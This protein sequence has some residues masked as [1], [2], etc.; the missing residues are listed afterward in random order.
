MSRSN[1]LSQFTTIM[2]SWQNTRFPWLLLAAVSLGMLVLAHAVFQVWLFM[3]PCEHCVYIRFAFFSLVLGGGLGAIA[4]RN[5]IFKVLGYLVAFYGAVKGIGY[6]LKLNTIHQ[7]LRSDEPFGVQGC[8]SQP[9]FP[10]GLPLDGWFPDWFKPTGDCGFD[11]PIVPDGVALSGLQ[12]WLIDCYA[13]GWYLWPPAHFMN[14]AQACLIVFGAILLLLAAGALS[15][16]FTVG[17][18]AA[19]SDGWD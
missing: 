17:R 18:G 19:G 2:V 10:L 6:S 3:Q 13:E 5:P 4:P 11:S 8:S 1:F 16:L 9:V 14:M 7:V 12:Q 15:W